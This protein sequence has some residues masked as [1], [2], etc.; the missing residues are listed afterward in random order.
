[1]KSSTKGIFFYQKKKKTKKKIPRF[2]KFYST[3]CYKPENKF[4]NSYAQKTDI[5]Y[6]NKGKSAVYL[7][8]N[9]KNAR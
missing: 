7:W 1:M 2:H 5:L 3:S 8:R 6:D 9:L 4:E